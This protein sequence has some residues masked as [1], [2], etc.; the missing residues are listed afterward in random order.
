MPIWKNGVNVEAMKYYVKTFGCQM[1][2]SD[3]ER[4]AA[5]LEQ[6][7][8]Q[9]VATTDQADLVVLNTC[10]IRQSAEDRMYGQIAKWR[11]YRQQNPSFVGVVTGCVPAKEGDK[12]T[13]KLLASPAKPASTYVGQG[14][15]AVDIF[16]NIQDIKK[17]PQLVAEKRRVAFQVSAEYEDQNVNYLKTL[18]RHQSDFQAYVPISIGCNNYCTYCVVPYARG[19]EKSRNS[20]E[21]LRECQDLVARGYKEITLLGQNVN[22]YGQDNSQEI[23]FPTLLQQV[24]NIPGDFWIRFITSHPKDM[25]DKLIAVIA[26][27]QPKVTPYIHLAVQSGSN[28][29]LQAM[30]RKYTRED[31]SRLIDKIRKAVPEVALS[32]DIIVGFPGETATDFQETVDLFKQVR[33]NMAYISQYSPRP[34][35]VAAKLEDDV[36]RTEK[37]RREKELTAI[38]E[39]IA[40]EENEKD[41]DKTIRVLIENKKG[42]RYIGRTPQ[43]KVAKVRG[44]ELMIGQLVEVD[45]E[46]VLA[47]GLE[48]TS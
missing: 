6:A 1:N 10:S 20:A 4:I 14:E 45:I 44:R 25:S 17:L 41:V 16:L 24:A 12:L 33:F 9:A 42:G 48:G 19:R 40:L 31:Y 2:K 13:A 38:L 28:K 29:I 32:T 22:S 43:G 11:Q 3:S 7:G 15:L 36:S 39:E 26:A 21:I 30:N 35:T 47:W 46:G 5:V 34:G 18:P 27:N 37:R 23:D 8:W